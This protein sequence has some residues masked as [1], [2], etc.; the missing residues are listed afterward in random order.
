MTSTLGHEQDT[1][2][3]LGQQVAEIASDP[4]Q[5]TL[6]SLWRRHNGLQPERPMVMIDQIP[7]H[8]MGVD[9]EL[10]LV[11]ED[12]LL[13]QIET[14]LRR[15]LYKWRHLRHDLVIEPVL[16]VSK[17]IR[18]LDFGLSVE[19]ERSVLDPHNDVVG[20]RYI[21]QIAT[22]EDIAKIRLGDVQLDVEETDRR[23]ALAEEIFAG[24]LEVRMQGALP[25]FAAW[26][27]LVTLRSPEGVLLDIIDRPDFTHKL[28]DHFTNV[29]LAQL[30]ILEDK[31]LLGHSQNTIHCTGA[32]TDELPAEGFDADHPRA[33]DL[34]TFGMA[35]IFST[36]SPSMH[37]EFWLDYAVKWFDRFGLGY[38]GC[39]E[40][41][42]KKIDII[43]AVP[44]VRK[45]SMSPW[46]DV[47]VGAERIGKDFVFSRKPSPALLA[48]EDW[49]PEAVRK[50]L[51]E[52]IE[53][54]ERHGCPLEL[55]LKDISTVRY[56]PERLWEWAQIARELVGAQD[57]AVA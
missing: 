41:L 24:V 3:E 39:C 30:D 51:L 19:E 36:V 46:V 10:T 23:Q 49:D 17:V 25:V 35:Q 48:V 5:E 29:N 18:G 22:E 7:W 6:K 34:W 14:G 54:C 31:G 16:E 4:V 26:D 47:E 28:M 43:R 40:P 44:N 37:K 57:V 8:E 56:E 11:C 27:R 15:L 21:D 50:D 38:Y 9:G 52:T 33:K 1:L 45:I 2:R 55:I 32:N 12:P 42:D 20:H 13:R 53:A